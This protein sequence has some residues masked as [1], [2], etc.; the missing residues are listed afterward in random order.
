MLNTSANIVLDKL[1]SYITKHQLFDK[2]DQLALA[3]SGGKD[4][5][6]AAHLLNNLKIPFLMVH[7]NF[8]LRGEESDGDEKFVSQ[9]ANELEYCSNLFKLSADTQTHAAERKISIQ[10]AARQIRYD[11]FTELYTNGSLTKLIT[12]HHKTDSLETFF[13]NLYR[14]SGIAGLTGISNK[15]DF[16]IRPLLCFSSDEIESYTSKNNIEFRE[17]SSNSQTK[18]LRNTFRHLITPKIEEHLP[19]FESRSLESI[20]ILKQENESLTYLLE[21][22]AKSISIY[23]NGQFSIQKNAVYSF[24]QPTVLLYSILDKFGFNPTQ[25][26]QIG[27]LKRDSIGKMFYSKTHQALVDRELIIVSE[28]LDNL[29]LSLKISDPGTYQFG[30]KTL[31]IKKVN[32]AT[33]SSNKFEECVQLSADIFPL[34]LRKWKQGDRFQ[35]LGMKG[36]KLISDFFIDEKINLNEKGEITMLC[37]NNEVLWVAGHRISEKVKIEDTRD[38]YQL[39]LIFE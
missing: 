19:D 3:I 18:Y 29:E 31:I 8:N 9:L 24:P 33:F 25:C 17:D 21:N 39:S 14:K 2:S 35:P 32:D 4:S 38:I 34:T 30:S 23:K 7:V 28:I 16:I 36:S 37:S 15:R 12:A 13:I 11:Y 27:V 10:E 22:Y 6:C 20:E 26:K 1:K 5:V